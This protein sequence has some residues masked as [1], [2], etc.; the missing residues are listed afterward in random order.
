MAAISDTVMQV[1]ESQTV[2][3][4]GT[5]AQSAAITGNGT[6]AIVKV[7]PVED[8]YW[9]EGSNPTATSSNS[10]LKGGETH[11]FKVNSG[12]KLAFLQVSTGGTVYIDRMV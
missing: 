2:T 3:A 11:Y 12:N 9:T 1:A 10:F 7:H 6:F 5:S 4:S 8:V